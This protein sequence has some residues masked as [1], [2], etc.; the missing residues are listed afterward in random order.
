MRIFLGTVPKNIA[1]MFGMFWVQDS[2]FL[3][4][5]RKNMQ[6]ESRGPFNI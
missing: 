1:V 4:D 2:S 3:E 5:I 6:F